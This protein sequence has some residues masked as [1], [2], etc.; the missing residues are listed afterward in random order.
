MHDMILLLRDKLLWP[1]NLRTLS[2]FIFILLDILLQY[3]LGKGLS[4]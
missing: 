3:D 1:A 4:F 2:Q